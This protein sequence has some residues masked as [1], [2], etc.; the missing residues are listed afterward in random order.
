MLRKTPHV[1]SVGP[2]GCRTWE[3]RRHTARRRTSCEPLCQHTSQC[4][5][6]TTA[7]C[8]PCHCLPLCDIDCV[9]AVQWVGGTRA[10]HKAVEP[11]C[12]GAASLFDSDPFQTDL[13]P[14]PDSLA[15]SSPTPSVQISD[16]F[17]TA[18]HPALRP[19]SC[20]S[21]TPSW[22]L[23]SSSPTPSVQISDPFRANIRPLFDWKNKGN[24]CQTPF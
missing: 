22:S 10:K 8:P 15:S 20:R 5:I 4:Y 9:V 16:P 24:R 23:A 3:T 14:L 17:Q 21:P 2:G 11:R 1:R 12:M 7:S 19:L 18:W 6:H 13:R